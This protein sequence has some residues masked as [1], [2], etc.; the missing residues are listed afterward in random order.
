MYT[1]IHDTSTV[2]SIISSTGVIHTQYN[3]T[4]VDYIK[5]VREQ[6]RGFSGLE[7]AIAF[8]DPPSDFALLEEKN[9][10]AGN[11]PDLREVIS[12]MIYLQK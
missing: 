3:T 4:N 1:V 8:L 11:V 9:A 5:R 10:A 12:D 7:D 6:F 2:Y